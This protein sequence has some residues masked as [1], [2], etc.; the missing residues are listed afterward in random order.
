VALADPLVP[1]LEL[2]AVQRCRLQLGAAADV[3]QYSTAAAVADLEA[4]RAALGHERIDLQGL[5]YGTRVA[6]EY[7]RAHPQ[8]VRAVALLG[9]VSPAMKMPA[10]YSAGAEAVLR[11]LAQQCAADKA[12]RKAIPSLMDDVAALQRQLARGPL[13]VARADG[14]K[15]DLQPGRFWEAVRAQLGTA[16]TQRRLPWLLH[17]AAAGRFEPLLAATAPQP[18]RHSNGALLAVSCPEDTLHVTTEE[19]AAARKTVF[20]DYR[21]QQQIAACN[22][23]GVPR[24]ERRPGPVQADTPVLLLAGERDPVSQGERGPRALER[25][26]QQ[27]GVRDI[28][29]KVYPDARHELFNDLCRDEV[30]RDLIDWLEN[31]LAAPLSSPQAP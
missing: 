8:R 19:I 1:V 20:G 17:E 7:L 2:Q 11:R 12:C 22:V 30:T 10:P 28:T 3:A 25:K 23:W 31:R 24:V 9:T 16:I 15:A 29:V 27:C 26:Y 4:V 13:V 21:L 6:Q 5:S 14:S 18:D